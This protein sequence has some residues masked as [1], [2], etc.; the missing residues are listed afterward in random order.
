METKRTFAQ[1]GLDTPLVGGAAR[2]RSDLWAQLDTLKQHEGFS[3]AAQK[4]ACAEVELVHAGNEFGQQGWRHANPYV[5]MVEDLTRDAMTLVKTCPTNPVATRQVPVASPAVAPLA[6]LPDAPSARQ[7]PKL[8]KA[9]VL[10][11]FDGR[12]AASI[13]APSLANL[14]LILVDALSTDFKLQA[15]RITGHADRLNATGSA[16]YNAQLAQDRAEVVRQILIKRGIP[17]GA[18]TVESKA[19]AQQLAEAV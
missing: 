5:Q 13:R 14:D 15:V 8:L 11:D 10:F 7:Q 6:P 2:L 17:A 1:L 12:D 16:G 19:A 3:C 4:I 18:I 9:N